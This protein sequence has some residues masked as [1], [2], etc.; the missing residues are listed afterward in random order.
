MLCALKYC[1]NVVG[2][3]T[4]RNQPRFEAA[5]MLFRTPTPWI[6]ARRPKNGQHNCDT[7]ESTRRKNSAVHCQLFSTPGLQWHVGLAD[8]E[9]T[10]GSVDAFQ[11]SCFPLRRAE[12][13]A[14]LPCDS[15][16]LVFLVTSLARLQHHSVKD[17]SVHPSHEQAS[18]VVPC[19]PHSASALTELLRSQHLITYGSG[20]LSHGSQTEEIYH[21]DLPEP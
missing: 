19:Q 2:I 4:F 20:T 8:S 6:T 5:M 15:S 10:L 7:N 16:N 14:V 12:T 9:V 1:C 13:P 17:P 18:V 11:L 21:N 3:C